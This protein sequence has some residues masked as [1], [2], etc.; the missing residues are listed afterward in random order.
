[1]TLSLTNNPKTNN[2]V[3]DNLPNGLETPPKP[4]PF[5]RKPEDPESRGIL[6]PAPFDVAQS[7]PKTA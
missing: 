2:P 7:F 3:Y 4:V 6:A 1:M 5:A